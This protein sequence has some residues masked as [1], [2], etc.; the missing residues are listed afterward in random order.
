MP[1][2]NTT[3]T[4]RVTELEKGLKELTN[5]VTNIRVNDLPHLTRKVDSLKTRVS[6]TSVINVGAIVIGLLLAKAF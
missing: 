6:V 2:N 1:K 4:W 5:E 3:L